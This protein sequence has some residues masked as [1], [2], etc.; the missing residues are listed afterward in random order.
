[1]LFQETISRSIARKLGGSKAE[2]SAAV[3]AIVQQRWAIRQMPAI[4]GLALAIGWMILFGRGTD[5]LEKT[6][7]D[8]LGLLQS[9]GAPGIVIALLLGYGIAGALLLGIPFW[10]RRMMLI[11]AIAG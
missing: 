7:F 2:I 6:R 1:M 9:W 11:G 10:V 4:L 5:A 8:L 3:D